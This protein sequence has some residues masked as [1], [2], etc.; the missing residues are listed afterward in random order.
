MKKVLLFATA[1]L[2]FTGAFLQK[3]EKVK[4]RKNV[5]K[6]NLAALKLQNQKSLAAKTNLKL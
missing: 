6:G 1:A 4:R 2:L 5:Q 3:A